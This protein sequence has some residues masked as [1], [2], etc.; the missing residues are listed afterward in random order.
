[1]MEDAKESRALS[2]SR[3]SRMW[4]IGSRRRLVRWQRPWRQEQRLATGTPGSAHPAYRLPAKENEPVLEMAT[5][6]VYAD[7]SHRTHAVTVWDRGIFF[8]SFSSEYRLLSLAGLMAL[9]PMKRLHN[10]RSLSPVR[11]ELTGPNQRRNSKATT[12]RRMRRGFFSPCM[13]R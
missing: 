8:L 3:A 4:L 12:R 1:M 13:C 10:R 5:K 6:E 9:R 11:T 2:V 7:P